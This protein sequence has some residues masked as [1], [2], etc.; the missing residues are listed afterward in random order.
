MGS[1]PAKQQKVSQSCQSTSSLL[2]RESDS[3]AGLSAA[4]LFDEDFYEGMSLDSSDF[5]TGQATMPSV[6]E[7]FNF[8]IDLNAPNL[9]SFESNVNMDAGPIISTQPANL[10]TGPSIGSWINDV[11][12]FD[13][14]LPPSDPN[15]VI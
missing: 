6:S 8:N 11:F 15:L 7:D 12:D 1:S 5:T 13:A 4:P 14:P 10:T 3:P 9:S 2:T